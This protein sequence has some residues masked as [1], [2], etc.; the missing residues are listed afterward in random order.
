VVREV[1]FLDERIMIEV[2]ISLVGGKGDEVGE[3][4]IEVWGVEFEIDVG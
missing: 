4:E 3:S 1:C 2:M